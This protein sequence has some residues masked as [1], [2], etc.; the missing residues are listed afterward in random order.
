MN[1][2]IENQ[3]PA[4]MKTI[5][6]DHEAKYG[7]CQLEKGESGTPHI[8]GYIYWPSE[9]SFKFMKTM[10]TGAHI[11]KAKGT[12]AD[13]RKYCTKEEGRVAGPWEFGELPEKG[14][15]SD[16]DG[17]KI[18]L[19]KGM[20]M[21]EISEIHFNHYLRYQRGITSYK[22][23]HAVERDWL[24]EVEV[25]W[26]PTGSGKS[27]R[28]RAENPGAYWKSKNA[29]SSQ[30]WDNYQGQSTIIID[31][32]YGWLPFD[33]LL[34]LLDST[35]I[36]LDIKHGSVACSA[37]KI[38]FTSND[39]PSDWYSSE[40]FPW[41]SLNPLKRRI[42]SVTY[43]ATAEQ[44]SEELYLELRREERQAER[45]RRSNFGEKSGGVGDKRR[46]F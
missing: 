13:N 32:F 4:W 31:E 34:R 16:L 20:D 27:R 17:L 8:Q 37:K 36:Q 38:V 24:M 28:A 46:N 39:H 9:K 6:E 1:N 12:P 18:D 21:K 41:G 15:R 30:Y 26:G 14:K 2:P 5:V 23:L 22:V 43:I 3:W 10:F 33:F 44:P 45:D 29:S 42:N 7:I 11:E 19:D 40:R 25:F 35:P